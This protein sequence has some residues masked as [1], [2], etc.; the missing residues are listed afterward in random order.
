MADES[1]KDLSSDEARIRRLKH[2]RHLAGLTAQELAQKHD[3]SLDTL[4]YWESSSRKGSISHRGAVQMVAAMAK[5]G[6]EVT[7]QWI[8]YGQG[9]PPHVI[10]EQPKAVLMTKD[11]YDRQTQHEIANFCQQVE[12][13]V[14]ITIL[15]SAMQPV[16]HPGDQVGGIWIEPTRFIHYHQ[17][18]CIFEHPEQ[19]FICRQL[20]QL[21][22][23]GFNAVALNQQAQASSLVIENIQVER[24]APVMRVWKSW[25]E[26]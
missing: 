16:C 8:L 9:G 13:A 18:T 3:F 1:L 22:H 19:G 17:H 11:A 15:D 14:I 10:A 24:I 4:K 23:G 26:L 21:D 20:I 12:H 5:E 7:Y 2:L 6:I 25:R